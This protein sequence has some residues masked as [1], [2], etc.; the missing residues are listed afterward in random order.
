MCIMLQLQTMRT[1]FSKSIITLNLSRWFMELADY[2]ITFV[3][4]KGKINVL[5]DAISR[6]KH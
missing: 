1:F 6:L 5:V 4:S 2:N 3:H